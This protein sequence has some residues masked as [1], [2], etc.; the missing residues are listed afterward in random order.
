[1]GGG[2][3]LAKGA[4]FMVEKFAISLASWKVEAVSSSTSVSAMLGG[5]RANKGMGWRGRQRLV[6]RVVVVNLR[7]QFLQIE[8][9]NSIKTNAR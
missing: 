5:K 6:C 9:R 8:L 1:M 4:E 3:A 2:V 7:V